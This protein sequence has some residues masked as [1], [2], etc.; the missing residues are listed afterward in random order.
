[1]EWQ[2]P[3]DEVPLGTWTAEPLRREQWP[4]Y[5]KGERFTL[6]VIEV[7]GETMVVTSAAAASDPAW[8]ELDAAHELV[9]STMK[10]PS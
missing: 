2:A 7:D 3:E 6:T 8:D 4:D 9:L 5:S 10:L 1:M